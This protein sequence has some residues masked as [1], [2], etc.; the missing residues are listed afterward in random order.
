MGLPTQSAAPVGNVTKLLTQAR[1]NIDRY[2]EYFNSVGLPE[3]SYEDGDGLTPQNR[4]PA[5]VLAAQH[6]ALEATDEL[7]HLLLGPRGLLLSAPGDVS[8]HWYSGF[9]RIDTDSTI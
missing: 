7:H 9:P 1:D 4:P 6:L 3:P 8:T 2:L 5:E